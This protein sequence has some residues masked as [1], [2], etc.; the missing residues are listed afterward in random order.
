MRKDFA[1]RAHDIPGRD[2]LEELTRNIKMRGIHTL[3]F[4]PA[5]SIA[6][7]THGGDD[8]SIGMA[9]Y[10]R[11]LFAAN[12][13]E[14]GTLSCY[15]NLID[16]DLNARN[17]VIARF[18]RYLQL[19]PGFGTRIVA[20]ETG[21]VDPTFGFTKANFEQVPFET[22]LKTIAQLLPVAHEFG[23]F[24][25]LE[26]GV[27][28]PL[29]SLARTGQLLAHFD[30]DPALKLIIDPVNLIL[31]EKDDVEVVLHEAFERFSAQIVA[32]HLKDYV[33]TPDA[34]RLLKTVVPGTGRVNFR[35]LLEMAE[36]A[37]PFG[38]KCLDELPNG[39]LDETLKLPLLAPY[40][41]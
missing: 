6:A 41:G 3:A 26:P 38:I 16:P 19:A 14:I 11:R 17:R 21:S 22:L 9:N 37:Q 1:V 27:N 35:R 7:A 4:S 24:I 40:R 20:T 10:V 36:Q 29:Y 5:A 33:W 31:S 2:D 18:Q 30:N 28:H 23:T 12:D 34:P 13:I 32:V 8:V 39:Q 25:A 15:V